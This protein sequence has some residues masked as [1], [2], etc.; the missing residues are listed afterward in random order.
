MRWRERRPARPSRIKWPNDVLVGDRKLAGVLVEAITMGARVEAVV[1]GVGINV[2]T[3]A[4]PED[5][6][7]RATSVALVSSEPPDRAS[8]LAGVLAA[9][10]RD[11]HVVWAAGWGC[12]ADGSRRSTPFA[13]TGC[14]ATRGTRESPPGSTRTG[15]CWCVVIDGVVARWCAGEVH[16]MR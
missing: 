7:D 15:G 16:L 12:F 2:H 6:G 10:D 5:L 9:L 3:R 14:E 4:F 8:I 13:G 1:I 11:L